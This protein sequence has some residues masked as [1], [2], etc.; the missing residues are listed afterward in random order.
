M[1]SYRR[2]LLQLIGVRGYLTTYPE[3]SQA[4]PTQHSRRAA[5]FNVTGIQQYLRSNQYSWCGNTP[6]I[7]TF[8][9]L[10]LAPPHFTSQVCMNLLHLS[11]DL[12]CMEVSLFLVMCWFSGEC[13]WWFHI[14]GAKNGELLVDLGCPLFAANSVRGNHCTQSACW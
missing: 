4:F 8:Y 12:I 7:R 9:L 1:K 5:G 10:Y 13:W 11:F 3:R 14:L 6:L 2:R